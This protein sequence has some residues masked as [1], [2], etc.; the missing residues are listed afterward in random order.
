MRKEDGGLARHS[1]ECLSEVDWQNTKIVSKECTLRQRKVK[2]EIDSLREMHCGKKVLN[3][4]LSFTVWR[5]ILDIGI[6][7]MRASERVH[8]SSEMTS[9]K[10]NV[11]FVCTCQI[12]TSCSL[13]TD[14]FNVDYVR[15]GVFL[16]LRG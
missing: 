3:S 10:I 15:L 13:K 5:P 7:R 1:V 12:I 16:V 4:F 2:E 6:L 8:F 9:R 11:K 14:S